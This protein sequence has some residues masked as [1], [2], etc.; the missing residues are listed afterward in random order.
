MD[1]IPLHPSIKLIATTRRLCKLHLVIGNIHSAMG[2][3]GESKENY[4]VASKHVREVLKQRS[5]VGEVGD[6]KC[7][8]D[9]KMAEQFTKSRVYDR[10]Q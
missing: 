8:I 4:R 2:N 7:L 6:W 5:D 10:A 3:D 1:G 9:L